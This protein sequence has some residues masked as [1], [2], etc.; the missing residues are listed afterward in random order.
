MAQIIL[1]SGGMDSLISHRLFYP[2]AQPVFVDTGSRYADHD[3]ELAVQQVPRVEV[4]HIPRLTEWANGVVPYRNALLL[5][6]VANRTGASDLIV[7]AP[8]G[9]LI[10]DQQPAFH[11]AMGKVLR[12]VAILNPLRH[13]T[14]TQAVAAWLARGY[15]ADELLAS[16][17]CYSASAGHC[18]QCPACVKRWVALKNNGLSEKYDADVRQHATHLAKLGTWRDALRYGLRPA[19]E[20]WRAIREP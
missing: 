10:W 6:Y 4:L 7:S 9:E 14:K 5:A 3:L 17:S 1:L 18:G 13:L 12:D 8:R 19:L 11:K 16:R 20:A 15:R 2:F